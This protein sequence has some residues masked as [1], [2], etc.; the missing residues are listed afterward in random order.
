MLQSTLA[1][2]LFLVGVQAGGAKPAAHVLDLVAAPPKE[3]AATVPDGLGRCAEPGGSG[4]A[5]S[6]GDMPILSQPL[7]G[8]PQTG[9]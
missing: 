4:T 2:L 9:A 3:V 6:P 8:A 1:L 5:E 7:Y